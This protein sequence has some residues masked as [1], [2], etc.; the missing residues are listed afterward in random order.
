MKLRPAFHN[1][2]GEL[3][4][5]SNI[6]IRPS[7]GK[8][9]MVNLLGAILA[10]LLLLVT[11]PLYLRFIGVTRYGALALAWVLLG[12]FRPFGFGL[13]QGVTYFT[14]KLRTTEERESLTMMGTAVTLNILLGVAGALVLLPVGNIILSRVLE[15]PPPLR[16]EMR[17]ALPFLAAAIPVGTLAAAFSGFLQGH[18]KFTLINLIRAGGLLLFQGLP[19]GIVLWEGPGLGDLVG[20]AVFAQVLECAALLFACK[21]HF[22]LS[23][24]L[25][26]SLRWAKALLRYGRWVALS[27]AVTSFL[28]TLDRL[29]IGVVLGA[30]AVTYYTVP[31]S[32][33]VTRFSM[34]PAALVQALFPRFSALDRNR[35]QTLGEDALMSMAAF[36]TPPLVLLAAFFGHIL[37]IWVG[38]DVSENSKRVGEILCMGIWINSLA[39]IPYWLL[40]GQGRPNIV[41]VLHM[42]E[43][44]PYFFMLWVGLNLRGVEGAAWAWTARVFL[45]ACVLF[46]ACGFPL[47]ELAPLFPGA[48]LIGTT[49]LLVTQVNEIFWRLTAAVPLSCI[50]LAWAW[51][52]APDVARARLRTCASLIRTVGSGRPWR[53]KASDDL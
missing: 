39:N 36:V 16:A 50:A 25:F 10:V 24:A 5:A 18:E 33:I 34:G 47:R 11:V 42:L 13:G 8:N 9:F 29:A 35:G 51:H 15:I 32:I 28:T 49:F 31:Y 19:L 45:D 6:M 38:P 23:P 30:R 37:T 21:R 43:L 41:A 48:L 17:D 22:V 2:P 52:V 40:Q 4:H 20:A 3:V 7:L 53:E 46:G 1:I 26:P 12:Y 44:V 14:A 27:S